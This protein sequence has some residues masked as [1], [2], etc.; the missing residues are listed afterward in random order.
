MYL[1]VWATPGIPSHD[2]ILEHV[3]MLKESIR[4]GSRRCT[5]L[6]KINRNTIKALISELPNKGIQDYIL[7]RGKEERGN[8]HLA[9]L[10]AKYKGC[11]AIES[12]RRY[13]RALQKTG[14]PFMIIVTHIDDYPEVKDPYADS[15]TDVDLSDIHWEELE[16][17]FGVGNIVYVANYK[18]REVL[19]RKSTKYK[20]MI[21]A[22]AR[23]L[24]TIQAHGSLQ[25]RRVADDRVF[26]RKVKAALKN[27]TND[28]YEVCQRTRMDLGQIVVIIILVCLIFVGYRVIVNR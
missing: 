17:T 22:I 20:L 19:D 16:A 25:V 1:K 15:I 8:V 27:L 23:S 28:A 7:K 24:E 11:G 3:E 26:S 2:N 9:L 10:V 18:H 5:A 6:D 12:L 14:I 21:N 4:E 13:T